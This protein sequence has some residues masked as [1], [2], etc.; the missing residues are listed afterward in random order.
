MEKFSIVYKYETF[1]IA[2]NVKVAILPYIAT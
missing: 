1:L 2:M